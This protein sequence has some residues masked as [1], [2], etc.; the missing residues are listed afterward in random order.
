M[1]SLL[2]CFGCCG[3]S[4]D[5]TPNTTASSTAKPQ[6]TKE[7]KQQVTKEE[8][9]S[10]K[11]ATGSVG[12]SARTATVAKK[13]KILVIYCKLYLR[14]DT[15]YKNIVIDSMYGHIK[16]LVDKVKSGLDTVENCQVEVFQVPE[17]LSDDIL[18]M[19]GAPPKSSD[20]VLTFDL[21]NRL[22]EA[23]GFVFG[24]PT[25]FGAIC[26]QMKAFFD[27]LGHLWQQ[28]SLNGKLASFFFSTGTQGGGQ[29]TTAWT[30]ISQLAHLGLLY[31]PS[32]YTFGSEMFS[33]EEPHGGSP[34]GPGTFAG[35][36]GSRQP[37]NYELQYAEHFGKYFGSIV[38]RFNS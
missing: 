22:L 19:M 15:F 27:S 32:G 4:Q 16:T 3:T 26:A 12:E 11:N 7:V 37:S 14:L 36:D 28:G 20:P 23:D 5:E 24:F 18:K 31:V 38:R 8:K 34:Y 35:S 25:R 33:F 10:K 1:P 13:I 21:H 6:E 2:S 30:A 9:I 17:T 29:E